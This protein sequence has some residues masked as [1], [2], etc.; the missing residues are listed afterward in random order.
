MIFKMSLTLSSDFY[1]QQISYPI[2]YLILYFKLY[3]YIYIYYSPTIFLYVVLSLE[4]YPRFSY[5]ASDKSKIE[6][7]YIYISN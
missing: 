2:I 1:L 5:L 4:S 6:G 7:V 3:I